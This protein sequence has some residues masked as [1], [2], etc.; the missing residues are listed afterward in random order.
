MISVVYVHEPDDLQCG[1]AVLAMLTGTDVAR[2]AQE[3]GNSRETDLSEMKSY[4][5]KNGFYI[6]D[7]RIAVRSRDM[8][9]EICLLSLETPRCWH[10]SLYCA[11]VFYDPEHGVMDDFPVSERRY[12]WEIREREKGE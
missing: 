6:S 1:Q 8:L 2:V 9:P 4:L 10:W 12:Y 3:L 5:R 7:N 11:G